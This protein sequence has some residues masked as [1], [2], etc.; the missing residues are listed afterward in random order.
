MRMRR[1]KATMEIFLPQPARAQ[2]VYKLIKFKIIISGGK[3]FTS[4]A[5]LIH[6]NGM[7]V[8]RMEMCLSVIVMVTASTSLVQIFCDLNPLALM[9][10]PLVR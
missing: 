1:T 6:P 7:C 5:N 3:Y 2:R 8:A 9:A 10:Q 4:N